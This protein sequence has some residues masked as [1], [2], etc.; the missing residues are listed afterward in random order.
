MN[1]LVVSQKMLQ[2]MVFYA[3]A[4]ALRASGKI[5]DFSVGADYFMWKEKSASIEEG[6]EEDHGE[7]YKIMRSEDKMQ[8]LNYDDLIK[9]FEAEWTFYSSMKIM[10]PKA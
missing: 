5:C 3:F 1:S 2:C 8:S 9:L 4:A 10:D 6:I 7:W